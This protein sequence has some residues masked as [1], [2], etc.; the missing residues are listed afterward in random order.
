MKKRV[1][2]AENDLMSLDCSVLELQLRTESFVAIPNVFDF[3]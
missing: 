2:T 3:V 1:D